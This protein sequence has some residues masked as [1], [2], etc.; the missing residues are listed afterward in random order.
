MHDLL[1]NYTTYGYHFPCVIRTVV[2][3]ST[4][5]AFLYIHCKGGITVADLPKGASTSIHE[6]KQGMRDGGECQQ[7]PKSCLFSV[8]RSSECASVPLVIRC[9]STSVRWRTY[10]SL[11]YQLQTDSVRLLAKHTPHKRMKA[12]AVRLHVHIMRFAFAY[13][14]GRGL[15]NSPSRPVKLK[16]NVFLFFP[17]SSVGNFSLLPPKFLFRCA[18]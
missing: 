18:T 15:R 14:C 9:T 7:M 2:A 13:G 12:N 10:F 1:F 16:N 5:P 8:R 6:R 4:G 11:K 3:G 17:L